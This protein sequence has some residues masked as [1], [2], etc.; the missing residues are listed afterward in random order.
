MPETM[1]LSVI[2][3]PRSGL[4]QDQGREEA[5][6]DAERLHQL[7]QRSR[8]WASSEQRAG[9]DADGEL[10]ELGRLHA[11]RSDEEPATRTV[12]RRCDREDGDAEHERADEQQRRE[13]AESVVVEPRGEGERATA[14]RGRRRPA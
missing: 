4:E 13:R 10:R 3:V 6:D 9:P 5:D 12:D 8:S 1:T 2:V 14:R 7:A 11:D